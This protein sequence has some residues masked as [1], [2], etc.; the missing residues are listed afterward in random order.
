MKQRF[1]AHTIYP[2]IL[3]VPPTE[4]QLKGRQKV[5]CLSRLA[6]QALGIS[7]GKSKILLPRLIKEENG[8]PR[9]FDGYYWSLAH[10]SDFV[11]AVIAPGPVGIDI[12]RIRPIKRS[13]FEKIAGESEW[14]LSA[15]DPLHQFFRYWTAKEAVLKAAAVGLKGLSLCR[16]K[17]IL[18]D[19]RLVV[20]YLDQ[21]WP[22]EQF[23]FEK[24]MAA[25]VRVA[26]HI[27]WILTDRFDPPVSFDS[28]Q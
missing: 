23:F 19:R 11:G 9:P 15:A 20:E 17:S 2:T 18:D 24:H 7:A 1:R 14:G 13:L 6:R 26:E 8:G 25:V 12:E 10:K 28:E 4:R 21:E 5:V 27:K 22:V 3:S 16:I